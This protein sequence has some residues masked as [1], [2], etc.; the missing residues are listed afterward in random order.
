M[1]TPSLKCCPVPPAKNLF[2]AFHGL[3][4]PAFLYLLRVSVSEGGGHT[5]SVPGLST[6]GRGSPPGEGDQFRETHFGS[7]AAGTKSRRGR[8]CCG[9]S[10]DPLCT[11]PVKGGQSLFLKI[12][13]GMPTTLEGINEPARDRC[14]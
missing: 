6:V 8:S 5:Q 13:K 7:Q 11:S 1:S 3:T 2:S 14:F 10:L 12:F 4:S 9:A